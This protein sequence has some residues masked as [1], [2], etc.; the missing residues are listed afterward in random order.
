M[1]DKTEPPGERVLVS[2][3][4]LRRTVGAVGMLLPLGVV[5]W[6]SVL[7]GRFEIRDSIS[8]Y[9]HSPTGDLFV[10]ALFT[11]AW[12]LFAY[13]GP[14]RKDDIAGDLACL[15]ALGVTLFPHDSPAPIGTFHFASAA[16]LFLTLAYFSI[17]LFTKTGGT[18]AQMTGRKVI[19]NPL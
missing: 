14:E 5:A 2:F 8:A 7:A 11:I 13:R 4:T 15:F 18:K 6:G 12:F 3:L 19:R 1:W 10:G 9:Y 16:A 17:G